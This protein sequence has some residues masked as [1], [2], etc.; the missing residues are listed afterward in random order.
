MI[1]IIRPLE[2]EAFLDVIEIEVTEESLGIEK[3][4]TT[5]T[6]VEIQITEKDLIEIEIGKIQDPKVEEDQSLETKVKRGGVIIADN[7]DIL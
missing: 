5:Q 6:E 3:G 7:Q 2:A 4:H 1:G